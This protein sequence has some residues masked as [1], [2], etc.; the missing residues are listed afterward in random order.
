[1]TSPSHRGLCIYGPPKDVVVIMIS[2][3][4]YINASDHEETK[5]KSFLILLQTHVKSVRIEEP[6]LNNCKEARFKTN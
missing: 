1:M 5:G 4:S 3:A 6:H 2:C